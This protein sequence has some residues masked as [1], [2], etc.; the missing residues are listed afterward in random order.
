MAA[1]RL[2]RRS[3]APPH[4]PGWRRS[5]RAQPRPA[6]RREK[7]QALPARPHQSRLQQ[8][9]RSCDRHRRHQVRRLRA[10]PPRRAAAASAPRAPAAGQS[11]AHA[12][13]SQ[14]RRSAVFR[15]RQ[16]P[17]GANFDNPRIQH[18][19]RRRRAGH[20]GGNRPTAAPAPTATQR[21]EEFQR[22]PR[23]TARSAPRAVAVAKPSVSP[24]HASA[25]GVGLP[26]MVQQRRAS[27]SLFP[28]GARSRSSFSASCTSSGV[29]LPAS[30][31]WAITGWHPAAEQG[32]EVVDQPALGG[33][34]A[35]HRLED[36]G[37]ADL[38]GTAQHLLG[39]Q[40]VRPW[41]APWC[42]QAGP[43]AE[44]LLD[45][46]DRRRARGPQRLHDLEFQLAQFGSCIN[47]F[48]TTTVGGSSPR[49][50]IGP[51]ASPSP[52]AAGVEQ[53]RTAAGRRRNPPRCACQA[54]LTLC[55][56][57]PSPVRPATGST[58]TQTAVKIS[59]TGATTRQQRPRAAVAAR[60]RRPGSMRSPPPSAPRW[61]RTR[62]SPAPRSPV[63]GQR[64]PPR[65]AADY[66]EEQE[67]AAA[68]AP[69]HHRPEGQQPETVDRPDGSSRH[70]APY[71]RQGHRLL[72]HTVPGLAMWLARR[73]GCS[74]P[75]KAH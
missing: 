28:L 60:A 74:G 70:A 31:S 35:R 67:Q 72:H 53:V 13:V 12:A 52:A 11:P 55:W 42:R 33:V 66:E 27:R 54:M 41:S 24:A 65:H 68:E 44:A 63:E 10:A 19:P 51:P 71:R 23:T 58:P 50:A 21:D 2:S 46:T 56:P 3:D 15:R 48:T 62:R 59:T 39:L 43:R 32:Q 29:S 5:R 57:C 6:G 25:K 1:V 69:R 26:E 8:R 45:V 40:P 20:R 37:V 61:R 36:M 64:S 9:V 34:A 17:G 18:E 75:D 7:G 30:I 16:Q 38:A 73:Q 49:S 4:A 14:G 22:R 47:P